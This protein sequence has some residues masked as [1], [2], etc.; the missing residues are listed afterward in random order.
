M[1]LWDHQ[2]A[3][4]TAKYRLVVNHTPLSCAKATLDCCF[5][6]ST[7]FCLY[8]SLTTHSLLAWASP[9]SV[10]TSLN[11]SSKSVS[12]Y[13]F[14]FQRDDRNGILS[15]LAFLFMPIK[16]DRFYEIY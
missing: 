9:V 4:S 3:P 16:K 10:L 13:S 5:V 6:T 1:N 2:E 11:Y 7:Q 12:C 8:P 15:S 14:S